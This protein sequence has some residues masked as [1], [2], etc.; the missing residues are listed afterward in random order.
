MNV[1]GICGRDRDAAAALSVDGRVVSAAIEESFARVPGIGYAQTGGFPS[2]AVEACLD[3]AGIEARAIDEVVVVDDSNSVVWP[4]PAPARVI[5]AAEADARH[6]A[7]THPDAGAIVVCGANPPVLAVFTR[8]GAT[9]APREDVAGAGGLFEGAAT[10]RERAWARRDA[11]RWR[12][13]TGS[14]SALN[15]NSPRSS[16]PF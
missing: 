5:D 7:M 16:R 8:K 1:L 9:W 3:A 13:S 4:L 2:H 12:S 10:S 11:I 6:A 14:A 15:P